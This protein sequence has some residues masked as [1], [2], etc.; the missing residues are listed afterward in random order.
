M[1]VMNKEEMLAGLVEKVD[2]KIQ[3]V[4]K[5]IQEKALFNQGKVMEACLLYTSPSPRD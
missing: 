1:Q 4:F 5:A 2:N 3:P